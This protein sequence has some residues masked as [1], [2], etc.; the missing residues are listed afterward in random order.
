MRTVR[1]AESVVY[2]HVGKGGQRLGKFGIVLLLFLMEAH[3]FEEHRLTR[4]QRRHFGFG[5]VA[6]DVFGQRHFAAEQLVEAVGDR[7]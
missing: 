6:D 3:V 7:L 5:V 4:L 1:G 2:V